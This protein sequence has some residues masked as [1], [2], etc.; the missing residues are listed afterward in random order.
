M[1]NRVLDP[2]NRVH[3]VIGYIKLRVLL[4][5]MYHFNP[6]FY[7]PGAYTQPRIRQDHYKYSSVVTIAA[8]IFPDDVL[9]CTTFCI[10][11]HDFNDIFEHRL[12][13]EDVILRLE[14]IIGSIDEKNEITWVE[15]IITRLMEFEG[16][17]GYLFK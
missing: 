12:P 17:F 13:Y 1:K 9:N 10:T 6:R 4:K 3:V 8:H 7:D 5:N 2:T 16:P 14:R 11:Q 15:E